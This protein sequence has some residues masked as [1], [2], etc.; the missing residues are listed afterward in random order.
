VSIVLFVAC[1]N[2]ANLLL[3]RARQR[4]REFAIRAAIG[5]TRGRLLRQVLIESTLLAAAA[6]AAGWLV[7]NWGVAALA[8]RLP[9]ELPQFRPVAL[10]VRALGFM[11]A[12]SLAVGALVGLVPAWQAS[13]SR[14]TSALRSGAPL[15]RDR[16]RASSALVAAQVAVSMLLLAG[17]GLLLRSV[18]NYLAVEPG[19]DPQRLSQLMVTHFNTTEAERNAKLAALREAFGDIPGIEAVAVWGR[20]SGSR[21]VAGSGAADAD[22]V[23][24][25]VS[26]DDFFETIGIPLRRGRRFDRRD[27]AQGAAA[28]LVNETMARTRWPGAEALGRTFGDERGA[29]RFEVVGVAGDVVEHPEQP[30]RPRFYEPYERY[31]G[32]TS[33]SL[34]MVRATADGAEVAP[35]IRAALWRLEPLTIPPEITS[36]DRAFEVLAAP[37]RTLTQLLGCFA[38]VAMLLTGVGLYGVIN[39]SVVMRTREIGLRIALGADRSAVLRLVAGR[40]AR[41]VAAGLAIGLAATPLVAR[42]L[43]S[44]LFGV[45]PTDAITLAAV[46]IALAVVAVVASAVPARRATRVDPAISLRAD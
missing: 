45:R 23:L 6:G 43:D 7:A 12:L 3:T 4:R 30:V 39:Q 34:F 35:A 40:A 46:G 20:G 38:I 42:Y 5:A 41:L 37:R 44:V 16:R 17:A 11:L 29:R 18:S 22:H 31:P 8:S 9:P 1:A 27:V 24:V 26:G 14:E 2:V 19:Y 13:R 10:D 36:L 33:S 28:V 32:P 25:G 21:I 15:T